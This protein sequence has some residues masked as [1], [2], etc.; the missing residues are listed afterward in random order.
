[1]KN[2]LYLTETHRAIFDYA[3]TG[4]L[5][6]YLV[7]NTESALT[8]MFPLTS[9]PTLL[10]CTVLTCS[11]AYREVIPVGGLVSIGRDVEPAGT[12]E[13]RNGKSYPE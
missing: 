4:L 13:P 3:T 1:M 7:G 10:E 6:V 8:G 12:P 11:T 5:S 9:M 2:I